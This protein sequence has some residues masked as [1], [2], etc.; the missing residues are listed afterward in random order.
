MDEN[1]QIIEEQ[2][3]KFVLNDMP[4]EDFQKAIVPQTIDKCIEMATKAAKNVDGCSNIIWNAN[5]CFELEFFKSCPA[6]KQIKTDK[7]T[8]LREKVNKT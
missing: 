2:T 3:R 4:L 8:K 7:C 1:K 5:V 6:D